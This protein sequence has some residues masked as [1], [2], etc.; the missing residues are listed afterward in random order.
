VSERAWRGGGGGGGGWG[1]VIKKKGTGG[2]NGENGHRDERLL[3]K[4]HQCSMDVERSTIS[5][6]R[7]KR[8]RRGALEGGC[9]VRVQ[10]GVV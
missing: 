1:G 5:V 2:A 6:T 9:Q 4:I 3:F 8:T 10:L 7:G